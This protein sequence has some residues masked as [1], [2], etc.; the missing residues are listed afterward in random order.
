MAASQTLY[1]ILGVPKNASDDAIRKAY[2]KLAREN[3]PDLKPGD[4]AAEERFKQI[5]A[6][7]DVLGNPKKRA[8]YDE[9]GEVGLKEGFDAEQA[10]AYSRYAGGGP[11][12]GGG[13]GGQG[14]SF[15]MGDLFGDFF[16]SRERYEPPSRGNDLQAVVELDFAEALRGKEITLQLPVAHPCGVCR[17]SGRRSGGAQRRCPTCRGQGQVNVGGHPGMP[18][19]RCPACLGTGQ[20]ADPCP[21]CGGQGQVT[22]QGPVTVRIPAGADN[23]SK[24][25]VAGRGAPGK[26]GAGDLLLTVK[27]RPHRWFRRQGNDLIVRLPLT[28]AEA[29]C[30]TQVTVPTLTGSVQVKIPPSTQT[31]TRL[32]LKG[33]GVSRGQK[34]GDLFVEVELRLPEANSPEAEA[35]ARALEGQYNRPVRAGLTL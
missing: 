11:S 7:N 27:V 4:K 25:R 35:A 29:L 33:K 8:L 34:H 12:A 2:R 32:R 31:G 15:D 16:G 28:V 1:S 30:G 20:V 18:K 24:L 21:G 9:F 14:Y 22:H 26:G 19:T 3:H 13:G 17:G 23:N 6:A 10:R 5:S